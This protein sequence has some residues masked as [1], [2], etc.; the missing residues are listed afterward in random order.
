M[1]YTQNP[2][3]T[4]DHT[5][6]IREDLLDDISVMSPVTAPFLY[7]F[8]FGPALGQPDYDELVDRIT[9]PVTNLTT[10]GSSAFGGDTARRSAYP[11][12]WEAQFPEEKTRTRMANTT[13]IVERTVDVSGSLRV[14]LQAGVGDE[15]G[16]K[17]DQNF[18]EVIEQ[19][20]YNCHFGQYNDG[21][22][23][24]GS[25]AAARMT[26]G[27]LP[28]IWSTGFPN[29]LGGN[30]TGTVSIA[31]QT[32]PKT[33]PGDREGY[34]GTFWAND[35]NANLTRDLF[36]ANLLEP[37][38]QRG[39]QIRN[40]RAF[41]GAVQKR[42]IST[43]AYVYQAGQPQFNL[44]EQ[45]TEARDRYI[46]EGIDQFDTNLGS[47]MFSLDR[48]LDGRDDHIFDTGTSGENHSLDVSD[49]MVIVEPRFWRHRVYRGIGYTPLAKTGDSDKALILLESGLECR[50]P[51]AGILCAAVSGGV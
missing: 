43:F 37:A 6:S 40:C 27:V 32:I 42:V 10:S 3:V 26:H 33:P 5:A 19:Y 35:T 45:R 29:S 23:D 49:A 17:V 18:L 11:S 9:S 39:M 2:E 41:L 1:V 14:A 13:V 34:S 16:Y 8:G 7:E 25:P 12:G 36:H 22:A 28:W 20:D 30:P 50:N 46:N 47:V 4:Y 38:Y 24:W 31:G 15:F 44:N 51:I 21:T 48:H